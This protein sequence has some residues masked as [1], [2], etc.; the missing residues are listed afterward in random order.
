MSPEK[1]K[2]VDR[3]SETNIYINVKDNY[4]VVMNKL[5][6]AT[7]KFGGDI[8]GMQKTLD[9]LNKTKVTFNIEVEKAK[10][11]LKELREAFK[12]TDTE[13]TENDLKAAQEKYDNLAS[14]LQ[15][16]SAQAKETERQMRSLAGTAKTTQTNSRS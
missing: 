7:K 4:S 5:S 6:D 16:V 11:E 8:E 1:R 12:K 13:V 9:H 10:K 14:T 2:G 3:V 15:A